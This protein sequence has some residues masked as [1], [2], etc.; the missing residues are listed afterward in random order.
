[1]TTLHAKKSL[2]HL[3]FLLLVWSSTVSVAPVVAGGGMN[4]EEMYETSAAGSSNNVVA[5]MRNKYVGLPPKG[6]FIAGA[7]AGVIG[8]R[9]VMGSAVGALKVAGVAFI[10]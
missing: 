6:R 4:E 7:A 1:M 9:L 10:T 8:S 2:K 3:L 5:V